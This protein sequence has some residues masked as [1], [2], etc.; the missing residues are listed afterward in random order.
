MKHILLQIALLLGLGITSTPSFAVQNCVVI[1]MHGKWGGPKSPYLKVL[2][3]KIEP[4]CKVELR[5]MPWSR[6]R[7]YDQTYENALRDMEQAV[8][9]Y[10]EGGYKKVFIAGQSFGAN[11]AMAYQAY[12]GGADGI[13]ALSP[14]HAPHS[15]YT[16][17][18]TQQ[19]IRN[20]RQA[21]VSGSPGTTINMTDVNQGQRKEFQ[22]RADVLVSYFEPDGLGNMARTAT[23]FKRSTP[24]LWVIGTQDILYREGKGYAFDKV[25]KLPINKYLVVNATHATAPEVASDQVVGW[26]KEVLSQ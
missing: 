21:V 2:A 7:N 12:I 6:I 11:A 15:M 1:L 25:P 18:I 20:A 26:I 17:G 13:I 8:K 19:A 24:F 4:T 16:S 14:G 23:E 9:R 22:I 5:D 10:R 3:D